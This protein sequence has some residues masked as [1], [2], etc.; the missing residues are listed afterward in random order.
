MVLA[1][2]RG[3]I[4]HDDMH[5]RVCLVSLLLLSALGCSSSDPGSP[6]GELLPPPTPD[7]H[8]S[9]TW[10]PQTVV[11]DADEARAALVDPVAKAGAYRFRRSA[12]LSGRLVP[13]NVLVLTGIDLV[14]IVS[15]DDSAA[16]EIKVQTEQAGLDEAADEADLS[17]RLDRALPVFEVDETFAGSVGASPRGLHPLAGGSVKAD[18][19]TNISVEGKLGAYAMSLKGS[20]T[21]DKSTLSLVL[22]QD[23]SATSKFKVSSKTTMSAINVAGKLGVHQGKKSGAEVT[24]DGMDLDCELSIG[25]VQSGVNLG[26]WKVPVTRRFPFMVGPIP[27]F[28]DVGMGIEIEQRVAGATSVITETTCH[29][30]E[31]KILY[32]GGAAGPRV[33]LGRVECAT[34]P[35][36]Y[37]GAGVDGGVGIRLDV[38]KVTFGVGNAALTG[39]EGG[40]YV[41]PKIEVVGNVAVSRDVAGNYPVI[42]GTCFTVDANAGLFA[43]GTMKLFGFALQEET[44]LLGR[45]VAHG[46]TGAGK[47]CTKKK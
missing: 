31:V 3:R 28:V 45:N 17:F 36:D 43:G 4:V 12:G 16:D 2:F 8:F 29:I 42:D 47:G 21:A 6:D 22:S 1:R 20:R 33:T 39:V 7:T 25:A 18:P 24:V 32:D 30:Y 34:L 35:K 14:R 38:P 23:L 27:M 40:L 10:K 26:K 46:Q 41:T 11:L 13:G 15:V 37:L 9:A 5:H 44:Q 19:G